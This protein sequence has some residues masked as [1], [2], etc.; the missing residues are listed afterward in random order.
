MVI[1]DDI[2]AGK[3]TTTL[4]AESRPTSQRS[5]KRFSLNL[6]Y[7]LIYNNSENKSIDDQQG[8]DHKQCCILS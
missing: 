3:H 8:V 4:G 7:N 6:D 2:E 1:R 5:S